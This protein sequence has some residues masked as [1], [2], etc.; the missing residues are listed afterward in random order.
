MVSMT[1]PIPPTYAP[2]NTPHLVTPQVESIP[3][4]LQ[5]ACYQPTN[6]EFLR[7]IFGPPMWAAHVTGFPD[8]PSNIQQ[9]RRSAC[10]GGTSY[11]RANGELSAGQTNQYFAVSIFRP[12][13]V[14]CDDGSVYYRPA[15]RKSLFLGMFVVVA[16][17]VEEKISAAAAGLLPPPSYKLQTSANS[18][19]WGWILNHP[20]TS[21][22]RAENLIDGLIKQGLCPD[23]KDTGMAGVT[24]FVRLPEGINTKASRY[25]D[26]QPFKCRMVEW[27]PARRVTIEELAG[28][29]GIDLNRLRADEGEGEGAAGAWA[30]FP[31][32]PVLEAVEILADVGDGAWDIVCPNIAAHT[33]G[34][35]SGTRLWLHSDGTVAIKCHHSC[36]ELSTRELLD[37]GGLLAP[38]ERWRVARAFAEVPQAPLTPVAGLQDATEQ[39]IVA[40]MWKVEGASVDKDRGR[41]AGEVYAKGWPLPAGLPEVLEQEAWQHGYTLGAQYKDPD[42]GE[43]RLPWLPVKTKGVLDTGFHMEVTTVTSEY[44]N[45]SAG[46]KARDWLIENHIM[47]GYL[48]A[49]VAPGGVGKSTYNLSMAIG[50][51]SGKDPLRLHPHGPAWQIFEK[52][53]VL[54]A[55]NE[56][57]V[58]ELWRRVRGVCLLHGITADLLEDNLH[59]FSGYGQPLVI[60]Q[61]GLRDVVIP[62]EGFAALRDKIEELDIDVVFLDPFISTYDGQENDN[63]TIDQIL[64]LYKRLA[65]DTGCAIHLTHHTP[66]AGGDPER[67]AGDADSSRGASA[68]KDSVR[69]FITLA[70]MSK[71]TAETFNI[72]PEERPRLFRMDN[73]KLNYGPPDDKTT[74]FKMTSVQ[75][76]TGDY[77]GVPVPRPLTA[78]IALAAEN[79]GK[80]GRPKKWS[81][82]LIAEKVAGIMGS[83]IIAPYAAIA[84]EVHNQEGLTERTVKDKLDLIGKKNAAMPLEDTAVCLGGEEYLWRERTAEGQFF[85]KGPLPRWKV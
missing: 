30:D 4:V 44:L 52:Q 21:R 56:D 3:P 32:H 2:I 22:A 15:R 18:F 73:G 8:D 77:V 34:D 54:I 36:Q 51:A 67:Y 64:T 41:L 70:K 47:R 11:T 80:I 85:H 46:Y 53:R 14:T 60:N 62:G 58:D 13:E 68:F 10:W 66:K 57:D 82:A 24:R 45:N 23:G 37:V 26:G 71:E 25:V 5:S 79:K 40:E 65:R 28:P 61:P 49:L 6:R 59:L 76:D 63:G 1:T 75:V 43:E 20:E 12:L 16:D 7:D 38:Y 29:F 17:D 84:W 48:T 72:D 35:T 42:F 74:W 31:G 33:D 39:S 78:E 9:E 81:P 83:R 19:Q 50:L 27:E 55:N 69:V